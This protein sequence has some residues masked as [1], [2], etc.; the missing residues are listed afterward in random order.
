MYPCMFLLFVREYDGQQLP[1]M[2]LFILD[3]NNN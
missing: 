1:I 2:T 3:N